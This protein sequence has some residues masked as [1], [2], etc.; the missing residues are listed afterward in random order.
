MVLL[1]VGADAVH[2]FKVDHVARPYRFLTVYPQLAEINRPAVK[3]GHVSHHQLALLLP[4]RNLHAAADYGILA[5]QL[6]SAV[7][8]AQSQGFI[9]E[10]RT[11]RQV[12]GHLGSLSQTS[13]FA[14][15]THSI[16]ERRVGGDVNL[17]SLHA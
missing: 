15:L 12:D 5:H 6:Q 11:S 14:R 4:S 1:V 10:V 16:G 8:R 17:C 9:Q 3:V 13:H 7:F 2:L